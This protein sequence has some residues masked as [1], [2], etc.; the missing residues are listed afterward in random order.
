M[1]FRSK[2]DSNDGCV[3]L[4]N[5]QEEVV[6]MLK[7]ISYLITTDKS[8]GLYY[9]DNVDPD[10]KSKTELYSNVELSVDANVSFF[11]N[12]LSGDTFEH[13][14]DSTAVL[15]EI[16]NLFELRNINDFNIKETNYFSLEDKQVNVKFDVPVPNLSINESFNRTIASRLTNSKADLENFNA[17]L[18]VPQNVVQIGRAHV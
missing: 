15:Q 7:G 2:T 8:T 3:V 11:Q 17:D 14:T 18:V 1:L 10:A 5:N 9:Y 6:E 12:V 16:T 13:V 4:Y